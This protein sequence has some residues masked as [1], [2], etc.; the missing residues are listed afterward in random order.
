[1]FWSRE[2]SVGTTPGAGCGCEALRHEEACELGPAGATILASCSGFADL[3]DLVPVASRE[4]DEDDEEGEEAFGEEEEA[5]R[6]EA[7]AE[8]AEVVPP[9]TISSSSPCCFASAFAPTV[10]PFST[11]LV[12]ACAADSVE[13]SAS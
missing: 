4:E 5:A 10:T 11:L 9:L 13:D 7:A 8:S 6:A 2:R 3:K 1:M 12:F